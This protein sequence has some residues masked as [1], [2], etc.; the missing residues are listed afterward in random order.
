MLDVLY[1]TEVNASMSLPSTTSI[2]AFGKKEIEPKLGICIHKV[3]IYSQ[4]TT[5]YYYIQLLYI[6]IYIYSQ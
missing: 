2:L 1:D 5:I 3:Y 4:Y 6:Y